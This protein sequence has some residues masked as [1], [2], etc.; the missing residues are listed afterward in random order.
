MS[1]PDTR[2]I[3][4]SS[5]NLDNPLRDI[6]ATRR[7]GKERELREYLSLLLKRKWL[8]L[9]IVILATSAVF[10]YSFSL[11]PIYEAA[12]TLQLDSKEY[13]YMEDSKGNILH[14][15]NNEDY[16]NT[17]VMLLSNPHLVREVVLKLDLEHNPAFLRSP[18][19]NGLWSAV[20][21]TFGS[22]KSASPAPLAA[23]APSG[24]EN[25]NELSSARI[26]QLEP[27]VAKV[28]AGLSVQPRDHT[29]LVTVSMSH[30]DPKLAAQIVD[31]LTRIFVN[32]SDKFET[33]SSQEAA[34]TL[35]RQIADLQTKLKETQDERLNYLKSNNLPLEKGEG[36]NLTADRLGKLSAQ[37]L[38]AENDRKNLEAS[39]EEATK[40]TDLST[41]PSVRESD[42]IQAMRK[43]IHTL[44]QKRAELLATYTP[45]WPEVKKVDSQIRQLQQDIAQSSRDTVH[46]FKSKLDA[47]VAREDK[48]REA[49]TKERETANIQT[50]AE[51]ELASLDQQIE[52]KRQVYNLLIQRQTEMQVDALAKTTHVAIVS[53][54][55]VP[56]A[57]VGPPRARGIV[58]TFLVSLLGSVGFVFLLDQFDNTLRSAGDVAH[59]TRLPTLALIPAGKCTTNSTLSQKLL[60]RLRLRQARGTPLALTSNLRSPTAEAYRHLRASL[61]FAAADR[62]PR[63]ILVT[64]GR[65]YEGKTT[66]AIN[67]AITF[68]QSGEEVLLIDCDLRRPRVHQYFEC[69]NSEGLSSYLSGRQDLDSLPRA[70]E[71]YPNL[72]LITAGPMLENPA[73]S[74]GSNQMRSLLSTL[75]ERFD[76][77]IIDSVPASSFADTSIISTQVDGVVLVVHRDRSSHHVVT[78]V[79]ERLEDVGANIY[80]VV[81]NHVQ[82]TRDDY[83]YS[84]YYYGYE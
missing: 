39:Y 16:R 54:P 69:S 38:D 36:R 52:T 77:I 3:A 28:L 23:P 27:L 75:G 48:L 84:N 73:D 22:D 30:T 70:H 49:Y 80:G 33:R 26:S 67:M 46:T 10:L 1:S 8:V 79:K 20:R 45:E 40:A 41:V 56:T 57:A 17:Q 51:V 32:N 44:G 21:R 61:L 29:S 2:L 12:A 72:K 43:T 82:P 71:R 83:Y 60:E 78:R 59:Y 13:V 65:P 68:A 31:T 14:S 37:L 74:L 76:R 24:P 64:S 7:S 62:Q 35:A 81:L 34:D 5:T 55:V 15:F 4:S 50:K 25:V 6:S 63:T 18:N 9:T 47:A 58:I 42:E 11:P 19:N 53:P 66:T